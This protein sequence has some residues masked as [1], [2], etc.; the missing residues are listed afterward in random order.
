VLLD[1]RVGVAVDQVLCNTGCTRLLVRSAETTRLW[2]I[3]L[4]RSEELATLTL[5][6]SQRYR[7]STHPKDKDKLILIVDTV[8]HVYEWKS[9][10]RLTPEKGIQLLGSM[11]PELAITAMMPCLDNQVLA[12]TF[13]ESLASRS[14]PKLLLW[15]T[16]DFTPLSESAAPIPNYQPLADQ[17]EHLVGIYGHRLVF[18]H[19]GGWVCSADSQSF[20]VEYFDR[21]FFFPSDWLSTTGGLMLEIFRNGNIA[22]VQRDEVAVVRR[23]MEHFEH[24]L[25]RDVGKRT[26]LLK[27]KMSDPLVE[28]MNLMAV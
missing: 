1:H 13:T 20:D 11:L 10:I 24:G 17:V 5:E 9:L 19:Q 14:K 12:T 28:R 23:G 27:G 15:K 22:F 2:S 3:E 25:S 16:D 6:K 8:A 7:W 18:L 4:G 21:H 26:S